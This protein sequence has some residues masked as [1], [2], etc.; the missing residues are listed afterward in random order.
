MLAFGV[1]ISTPPGPVANRLPSV[2]IFKPSGRPRRLLASAA[3]SKRT[4][5]DPNVPSGRTSNARQ[6]GAARIGLRDVQSF[7]VG[8][9]CQPVRPGHLSREQAHLAGATPTEHALIWNLACRILELLLHAVW[10]IGE[11]EVAVAVKHGVV[12]AVETRPFVCD[13]RAS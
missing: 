1:R 6:M 12:G 7:L 10:R 9:E 13:R 3:A 8:R 5:L 4:R 2:S 11:I